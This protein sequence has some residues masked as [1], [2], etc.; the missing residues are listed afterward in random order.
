MEEHSNYILAPQEPFKD[1]RRLVLCLDG[2]WNSTYSLRKESRQKIA[3][4]SNVL[5]IAR[6]IRR[7]DDDAVQQIVYYST[8]V[9]ASS[10]YPGRATKVLSFVDRVL[11]GAFGA[12][13]HSKVEEAI[14]FLTNNYRAGDEV[15]I[16]GF[17]RGSATARAV[18]QFLKWLGSAKC[19]ANNQSE[20][21]QGP[22]SKALKGGIVDKKDAYY[23]PF[24]LRFYFQT[25]GEISFEEAMLDVAQ[26]THH[27][28][29]A[30]FSNELLPITIKMLGVWDTVLALSS[31]LQ[32]RYYKHL[33][34][35]EL[36]LSVENVF[37]ALAIDEQRLDFQANIWSKISN[38]KQHVEQRWFAGSHSNIGGGYPDGGLANC[39]LD[40]IVSEARKLGLQFI[41]E[42]LPCYKPDPSGVLYNSK[43]G[44]YRVFDAIRSIYRQDKGLRSIGCAVHESIDFSVFERL[45][46]A[47]NSAQGFADSSINTY[48]KYRPANL[49]SFLQLMLDEGGIEAFAESIHQQYEGRV[50]KAK[51]PVTA[52]TIVNIIDNWRH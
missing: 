46:T 40:W 2:T 9:G 22:M 48:A 38:A 50:L 7:Q 5:K 34:A 42:Q 29:V 37:H 3:R 35:K 27:C 19:L 32:P 24:L 21:I 44:K 30:N 8:G 39:A 49:K 45:L 36:P 31:A 41:E 11:G 12:G 16:F 51:H 14:T 23:I 6:A 1:K 4:P 10:N 15:F 43:R 20:S 28:S 17:S 26:E 18:C 33:N 47:N 13:F 25:K 52:K